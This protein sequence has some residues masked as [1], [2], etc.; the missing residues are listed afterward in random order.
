MH[1]QVVRFLSNWLPFLL[2]FFLS[3]WLPFL[4][5]FSK[6]SKPFFFFFF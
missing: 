3:N 4:L 1:Y 6:P 5:F 2:Y